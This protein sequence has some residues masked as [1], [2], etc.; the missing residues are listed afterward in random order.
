MV[1]ASA[2]AIFTDIFSPNLPAPFGADQLPAANAAL[3]SHPRIFNRA[4]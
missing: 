2:T 4:D 1:A 3:P